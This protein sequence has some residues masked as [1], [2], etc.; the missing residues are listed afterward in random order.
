MN[1]VKVKGGLGNQM[2]QYAFGM[3]LQF[4]KGKTT[5]FD[6]YEYTTALNKQGYTLRPYELAAFNTNIPV[7]ERKYID[8]KLRPGRLRKLIQKATG[9]SLR[10][11][12]AP[13]IGYDVAALN[14]PGDAYFSGYF[15]SYKY[16]AGYEEQ[17]RQ[18]F[19]FNSAAIDSQNLQL[20]NEMTRCNSVS[21]HIRRGDYVNDAAIQAAHETCTVD[22]Y[23]TCIEHMRRY[24]ESPVFY[25]FS[26]DME[27]VKQTFGSIK[28]QS[29]FMQHNTG[30]ESW[31]DMYL[32]SK[33]KHHIIANSSFSW[34]GAWLN[35]SPNKHVL[36]PNKWFNDEESNRII[37]DLIPAEWTLIPVRS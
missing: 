19:E 34:W 35:S 32:M 12:Y 31:K 10:H 2:F 5:R 7:A 21:V 33:C 37:A 9:T 13:V 3:M 16:Y 29:Y 20:T 30:S 4:T 28:E 26:D 23:I 6:L 25:F 8:K 17:I 22:Y 27:W 11:Y 1:I 15:Q 14:L 24:I 36:A 18:L